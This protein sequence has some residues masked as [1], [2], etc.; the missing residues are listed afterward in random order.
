MRQCKYLCNVTHKDQ[1]YDWVPHLP[2]VYCNFDFSTNEISTRVKCL[3]ISTSWLV[4]RLWP[5]INAPAIFANHLFILANVWNVFRELLS[6][7]KQCTASRSSRLAATFVIG[8][9]VFLSSKVYIFTWVINVLVYFTLL[10]KLAWHSTS[11]NIIVG[12]STFFLVAMVI[13][14]LRHT[15]IIMNYNWLHFW[16]YIG[17]LV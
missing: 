3:M 17:H 10:I 8:D 6:L 15:F 13:C 4:D 7:S 1:F 5:V 14:F 2:M 9:L 16:C 12:A 11:L